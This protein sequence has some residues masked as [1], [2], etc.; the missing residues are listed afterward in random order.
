MAS[1]VTI[2]PE[3]A[4]IFKSLG[5]AVISLDFSSTATWPSSR[6]LAVAQAWTRWRADLALGPV[7]GASQRLAVDGDDLPL[8]RLVQGLDPAEEALLELV[9]VEPLEEA[10]E[11]VVRG[12][13]VG[14][15]QEGPQPVELG[16]AEVLDVVPGVGPGDDRTD[17]DGDDVEE[18]VEAGAVD[19]GV[20]QVGEVVGDGEFL[21]GG[22]GD[23]PWCLG[24][25]VED[26]QKLGPFTTFRRPI[27]VSSWCSDPG[28]QPEQRHEVRRRD[29]RAVPD[30]PRRRATNAVYLTVIG[31]AN[32]FDLETVWPGAIK[33]NLVDDHGHTALFQSAYLINSLKFDDRNSMS[34]HAG[35][36]N[37]LFGDGSVRFIKLSIDLRV[38]QAL[39]TK[40]GRRGRRCR[41]VLTR[42]T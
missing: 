29:R 37:F 13:A 4:S 27:R 25:E 16:V 24:V 33:E 35:G 3:I 42:G 22:H 21:V 20:G 39:G 18:F 8:G 41:P 26:Y 9:G 19:A 34:Y 28:V 12:D 31:S 36:S 6:W 17:G 40:V 32:H 1:I 23:P 7:E 11:G 5:M 30:A 15:V 38:Y 10:A 2:A 14:Q